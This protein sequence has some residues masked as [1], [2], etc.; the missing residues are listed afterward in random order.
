MM[1]RTGEESQSYP[2]PDGQQSSHTVQE[3]AALT[4]V[5]WMT[6]IVVVSL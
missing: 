2:P 3:L 5:S 4:V 6:V 1:N